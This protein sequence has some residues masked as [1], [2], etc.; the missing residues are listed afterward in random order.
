MGPLTCVVLKTISSRTAQWN[1][2]SNPE[3]LMLFRTSSHISHKLSYFAQALIFLV[4][5]MSVNVPFFTYLSLLDLKLKHQFNEK[6]SFMRSRE[7]A[8]KTLNN[9]MLRNCEFLWCT[10]PEFFF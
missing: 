3:F 9:S 1:V 7:K 8:F 6:T 10:E 4:L 2:I 5:K